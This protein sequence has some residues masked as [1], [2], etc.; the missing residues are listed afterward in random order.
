[1]VRRG[2][3]LFD[4]W[5]AGHCR[6]HVVAALALGELLAIPGAIVAQ[7]RSGAAG[8]SSWRETAAGDGALMAD[9]INPTA[10]VEVR[11]DPSTG[12]YRMTLGDHEVVAEGWLE[13]EQAAMAA[14]PGRSITYTDAAGKV[15]HVSP[16]TMMGVVVEPVAGAL[17]SQLKIEPGQ[18]L[19]VTEV[20]EGL[21]GAAGGL[22]IHDVI[23]AC[24]GRRPMTQPAFSELILGAVP[25]DVINVVAYRGGKEHE[26]AIR[27]DAYDPEVMSRV[28]IPQDLAEAEGLDAEE[29]LRQFRELRAE[30]HEAGFTPPTG[31]VAV[32]EGENGLIWADAA[33]SRAIAVDVGNWAA[34]RQEL[35]GIRQQLRRI[36]GAIE[37][38][39][40]L[41]A[42]RQRAA[43]GNGS[44]TGQ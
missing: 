4:A 7:D 31:R 8:S 20:Q 17:A 39:L 30:G 11:R 42:Q 9:P 23:V 37:A 35:D 15:L 5:R 29:I 33:D 38:L 21:A 34:L 22:A 12:E 10:V 26:F 41:E 13:I 36:E 40:E 44:A 3:G 1:M 28:R 16:R 6:R 18:G 19:L 24:N 32:P 27:L 43:V 2:I 25:G 14:L